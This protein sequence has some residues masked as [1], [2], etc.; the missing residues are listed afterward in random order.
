MTDDA[1]A[2]WMEKAETHPR[3][4]SYDDY[5]HY[6]LG[7]FDSV[8][9]PGH[10]KKALKEDVAVHANI[11]RIVVDIGTQ[12][13]CGGAVG[14]TVT[15]QV[16]NDTLVEEAEKALYK[17]YI[18]S[19]LIYRNMLKAIRILKKKGDV[20]LK[21]TYNKDQSQSVFTKAIDRIAFWKTYKSDKLNN[22]KIRILNPSFV[23]PKY[24]DSD[25]EE[26]D[27]CAIKYYEN[28]AEGI[29]HW[30]AE[31]WYTDIVQKWQLGIKDDTNLDISNTEKAEEQQVTWLKVEENTNPYGFIPIVHIA[32]TIDD[33]EFGISDLQD[34]SEIQ[35]MLNKALTDLMLGM[36]YQSFQRIFIAGA[37]TPQGK[38]WDTSAGVISELPN[39]DAKITVID[40]PAMTAHLD[41][42]SMLKQTLC[43]VTQ[44]P[45][46]AIG[47]VEGGI[48]SGY[49]LK[50][51]Y[52]PLEAKCNETRALIKDGFAELNQMIFNILEMEN[53][54]KYSE[55][56]TELQLK[57][58]LPI[59]DLTLA[60]VHTQ[61]IANGT[62]SRETAM[63]QEGIEDV[64][65]E[66]DK[67]KSESYDVYGDTGERARLE[68][69]QMEQTIAG[70]NLTGQ[71]NTEQ[72][73]KEGAVKNA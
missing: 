14:L 5:E 45:Q 67:I 49:A 19:G 21:V 18:N 20:F 16:K 66:L 63:Q 72:A 12:Y 29:D 15:S 47:M 55:L 31:V 38:Q 48:P 8:P 59:D 33:R 60:Q 65:A 42:I 35:N 70:L 28:D 11:S 39:P 62:I 37:M 25:Y 73:V 53:V 27:F 50:I 51:H 26:L 24:T 64:G 2:K 7:Q 3:L 44:I 17:I 71:P 68:A 61:Q 34:V 54:A 43:E 1:F 41:T 46:I 36:D 32:N 6:Y 10:I 9:I 40:P 58:G 23:F 30:F 56:S 52:Q 4:S 57:G 69:Q 13:I 22:I